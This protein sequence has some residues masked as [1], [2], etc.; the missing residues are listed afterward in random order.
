MTKYAPP[1]FELAVYRA[2]IARLEPVSK[3]LPKIIGLGLLS[4]AIEGLGLYLFLPLLAILSSSDNLAGIPGFMRDALERLPDGSQVLTLIAI[5]VVSVVLKNAVAYW[6]GVQFA[7]MDV[8]VGHRI[9][10]TLYASI[11]SARPGHLDTEPS[12]RIANALLGETWRVSRAL[13]SLYALITDICAILVFLVVLLVVSWKSTAIVIPSLLVIGVAL[14]FVTRRARTL[15]AE[16]VD[17]STA[18]TQRAWEGL[19]GLRTV[20][21]LG[22]G[23]YEAGRLERASDGIRRNL[24]D[25]QRL[26]ILAPAL[27]ETMVVAAIGVWVVALSAAGAELPSIAVFLVVLYRLQPRVRSLISARAALLELGS[28]ILEIEAVE[29]ECR[30][31][32]L[33]SGDR[34]FAGLKYAI[35]FANVSVRHDGTD[36]TSLADLSFDIPKNRT[37]AIVGP[38]G[39]GKST[40]VSLICRML[41]PIVGGV[42]IDG[43]DLREYRLDDWYA[44]LGIISQ[45]IFLFDASIADNISYG[46]ETATREDVIA[47]AKISGAHEFITEQPQGYNTEIGDRGVRLSGG[48]RQRIAFARALVS[49]PDILIM[50]EATNA[51]DSQSEEIIL[52]ALETLG[53]TLTIITVT[54]RLATVRNA[55]QIIVLN[56]G[57][58][59][60][61]GDWNSLMAREGVFAAMARLQ[62][63]GAE[64]VDGGGQKNRPMPMGAGSP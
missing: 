23:G 27:F 22:A 6:N 3:N 57:R 7:R 9:R 28:S 34:H 64:K 26:A 40:V 35:S 31:S 13:G 8:D 49:R 33:T 29:R 52:K 25:A 21:V 58:I 2:L 38:S 63:L 43:T 48:Q 51:L 44:K 20:R 55:D 39:A 14:H 60:E 12:G 32:Q 30:A 1:Q 42:S 18:Y 5:V 37:T 36:K 59:A 45:D 10:S 19:S 54:H 61:R 46:C 11:L 50:D 24:F 17:A 4:F 53:N 15:G 62:L 56:E 47:A 16:A 41:D